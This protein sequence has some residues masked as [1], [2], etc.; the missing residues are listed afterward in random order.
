LWTLAMASWYSWPMV[1]SPPWNDDERIIFYP[2]SFPRTSP[3]F[4]AS[5]R[6]LYRSQRNC[7]WL[8]WI[9]FKRFCSVHAYASTMNYYKSL[10]ARRIHSWLTRCCSMYA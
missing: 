7:Y 10:S 9:N 8:S 6:P 1:C 4:N 5:W 2:M 3:A